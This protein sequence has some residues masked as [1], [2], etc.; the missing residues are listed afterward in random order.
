MKVVVYNI[1]S[2]ERLAT[3]MLNRVRTMVRPIPTPTDLVDIVE[4]T[5]LSVIRTDSTIPL[6]TEEQSLVVAPETI[7]WSPI[8]IKGGVLEHLLRTL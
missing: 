5:D 8:R 1:E 7:G 6:E 4:K 2:H 3:D